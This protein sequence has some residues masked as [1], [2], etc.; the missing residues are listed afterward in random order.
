MGCT[1]T[2]RSVIATL[3]DD[4]VLFVMGDHG[5]TRTGDHGGDSD[6]EVDAALFVYSPKPLRTCNMT[7]VKTMYSVLNG[8]L[9][10]LP[11]V[12]ELITKIMKPL[13]HIQCKLKVYHYFLF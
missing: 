11:F 8:G 13:I 12:S 9:F 6:D 3:D 10:L 4:T 7:K 5:M 1:C 2:C